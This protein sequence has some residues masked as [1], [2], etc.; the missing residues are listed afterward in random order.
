MNYP[1]G[2]YVYSYLR[3][4][5]SPYYIGKGKGDRA[6]RKNRLFKP[7]DLARITIIEQNLT[8]PQAFELEIKLISTYGRKDLKTG[9][10]YNKTDGGEGVTNTSLSTEQKLAKGR[11]ST[12]HSNFG[13]F[14][15]DNRAAKE[16][17]IITPDNQVIKIKGLNQFCKDNNLQLS[18]VS[19]HLS[20]EPRQGKRLS[21]VKKYRFY[22]FS[23]E[24]LSELSENIPP[25]EKPKRG[26]ASIK[27]VCRLTD[28]KEFSK[29][30]ASL[31]FPDLKPYF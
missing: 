3:E 21:H 22:E 18:N 10:L 24:L 8:E 2:Y 4:D 15:A 19:W 23:N 14:G 28:K 30:S 26:S 29:A 17:I 12:D 16:Y 1:T 25:F 27:F 13:K 7:N 11:K 9:I 31:V 20:G 6:F 5:G